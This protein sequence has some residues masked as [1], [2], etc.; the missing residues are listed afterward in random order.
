MRDTRTSPLATPKEVATYLHTTEASLAQARYKGN[1]IPFVK[2]GRRVLYRWV[3]VEAYVEA[4]LM[5]RTD[6]RP[7][8]A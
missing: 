3:D 8:A 4:R 6:D 5:T 2:N 1:G 7:G